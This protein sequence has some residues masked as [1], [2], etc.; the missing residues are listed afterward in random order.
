MIVDQLTHLRPPNNIENLGT[1]Y[2]LIH[3]LTT[4]NT[5]LNKLKTYQTKNKLIP[6]LLS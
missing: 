2:T 5:N 6:Q 1:R 3:P 4:L